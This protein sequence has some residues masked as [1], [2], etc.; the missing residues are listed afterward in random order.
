MKQPIVARES[1]IMTKHPR[2]AQDEGPATPEDQQSQRPEAD[3]AQE[4]GER[5]AE[6]K[7]IARGGKTDGP[8]PGANEQPP[9]R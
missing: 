1:D 5:H 7:Q 8:V 9:R 4:W 3:P 6:G 2:P